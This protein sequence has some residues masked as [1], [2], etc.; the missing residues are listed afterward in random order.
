MHDSERSEYLLQQEKTPEVVNELVI[1]NEGLVYML[2]NKFKLQNDPDAISYAYE[3]L[4]NAIKTFDYNK[5][6][7]FSSYAV[8]CIYNS[9]C[10]YLRTLKQI[11]EFVLEDT[12]LNLF[13]SN[14]SAD[15][16]VIENDNIAF[17]NK[18]IVE[19]YNSFKNPLHK[20]V[21]AMWIESDFTITQ[22]EIAQE[23]GF[24]QSYVSRIIKKFKDKLEVML[25]DF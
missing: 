22:E 15:K 3:A 2:L 10:Y 6:N 5:G 11:K 18:K 7:K 8:V 9:L 14:L 17:I 13:R 23:L 1:L 21:I 25:N 12:Y 24:S 4:F 19:C 20:K 16:Q